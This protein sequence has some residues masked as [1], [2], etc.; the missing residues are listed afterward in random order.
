MLSSRWAGIT[1][2]A[3]GS[4]AIA[5]TEWGAS[6]NKATS[7][8]KSPL[9]SVFRTRSSPLTRGP[10]DVHVVGRNASTTEPARFIVVLLK[11]K[12]A[13]VFTPVKE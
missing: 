12:G 4:T 5:V 2:R 13:P 9:T 7:P 3:R 1:R 10:T 6:R 8:S 11:G